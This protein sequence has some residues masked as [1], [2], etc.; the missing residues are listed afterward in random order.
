MSRRCCHPHQMPVRFHNI[1]SDIL[2]QMLCGYRA[3]VWESLKITDSV[4]LYSLADFLHARFGNSAN[5]L[6]NRP[7]LL[8]IAKHF[9]RPRLTAL[10][11]PIDHLSICPIKKSFADRTEVT[12]Y[13]RLPKPAGKNHP[14]SLPQEVRLSNIANVS[15]C[16]PFNLPSV[17]GVNDLLSG[18][19]IQSDHVIS[20]HACFLSF[21]W[22]VARL[23]TLPRFLPNA[24]ASTGTNAVPSDRHSSLHS[25][26]V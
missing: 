15:C 10:H 16:L 13:N 20:R 18:V 23:S 4:N 24:D 1:K 25:E 17:S 22:R 12:P 21:W 19:E 3:H 8:P 7:N 26:S 14:R 11:L 2:R 5:D 9:H 6:R